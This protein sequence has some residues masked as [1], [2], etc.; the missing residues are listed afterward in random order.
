MNR[1]LSLITWNI[2]GNVINKLP[3]LENLIR[4]HNIVCLQEH[5]LI[6]EGTELLNIGDSIDLF[7][8]GAKSSGSGRPSGGIAILAS[9][10]LRATVFQV[11]DILLLSRLNGQ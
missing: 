7:A 4:N 11:S 9:K 6:N 3:I 1:E 2:N 5:F 8:F 10:S